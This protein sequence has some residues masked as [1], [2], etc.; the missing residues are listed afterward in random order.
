MIPTYHDEVRH[1]TSS[2]VQADICF[3]LERERLQ[4]KVQSLS[5][6][7]ERRVA[8]HTEKEPERD[9]R[10]SPPQAPAPKESGSDS[11]SQRTSWYLGVHRCSTLFKGRVQGTSAGE[12][13]TS[14]DPD[15]DRLR[16]AGRSRGRQKEG[17]GGHG[18]T[19]CVPKSL[20]Y[21]NMGFY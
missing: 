10:L 5:E 12:S 11:P 1:S 18:H 4:G 8:P 2:P 19:G 16:G 3:A 21:C 17:S 9:G 20:R 13:C 14:Q 7:F 15:Q 6:V